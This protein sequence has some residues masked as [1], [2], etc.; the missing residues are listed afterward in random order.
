LW[1]SFSLFVLLHS[2]IENWFTEYLQ[3]RVKS[4]DGLELSTVENEISG[5]E[6]A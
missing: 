3:L 4:E 2:H 1:P 6:N 5:R